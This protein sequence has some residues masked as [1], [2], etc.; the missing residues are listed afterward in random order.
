MCRRFCNLRNDLI[1]QQAAVLRPE[2]LPSGGIRNDPRLDE[3]PDDIADNGL[4]QLGVQFN[5]IIRDVI[6]IN[7][8]QH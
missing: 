6:K 7:G 3:P 5:H 1:I 2:D 4:I 8:I